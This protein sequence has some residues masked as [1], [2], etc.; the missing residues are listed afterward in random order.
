MKN[1]TQG[2]SEI[3]DFEKA[4]VSIDFT[5]KVNRYGN[6]DE[7]IVANTF[8]VNSQDWLMQG[9]QLTYVQLIIEV[10]CGYIL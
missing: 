5:L 9:L 1:S 6:K 8:Y 10:K 7:D 4:L 2:I 3:T